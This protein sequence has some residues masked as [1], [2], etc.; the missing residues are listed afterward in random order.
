MI[1]VLLERLGRLSNY[2]YASPYAQETLSPY[3]TLQ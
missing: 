1:I 3:L 2:A